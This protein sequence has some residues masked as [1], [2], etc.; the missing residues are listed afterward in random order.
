[1]ES[2]REKYNFVLL[3]FSANVKFPL[4]SFLWTYQKKCMYRVSVF[5]Y[6]SRFFEVFQVLPMVLEK[7]IHL[8]QAIFHL[9]WLYKHRPEL[10]STLLLNM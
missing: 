7:S 6:V 9:K 1:M 8:K 10:L 2:L 3:T 5:H 4:N